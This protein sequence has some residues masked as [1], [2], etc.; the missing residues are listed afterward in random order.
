M[1]G[2]WGVYRLDTFHIWIM[3][4]YGTRIRK[5]QQLSFIKTIIEQ[6][7]VFPLY[8]KN[9]LCISSWSIIMFI[10]FKLILM[11]HVFETNIIE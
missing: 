1:L 9:V 11:V 8:K 4:L 2:V 6:S 10:Y 7:A 3:L 5:N